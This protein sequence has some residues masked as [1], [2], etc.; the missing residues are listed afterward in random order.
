MQSIRT[1]ANTT[2][3]P[4]GNDG[5]ADYRHRGD[6]ETGLT[7]GAVSHAHLRRRPTGP[8]IRRGPRRALPDQHG[9][10]RSV[11]ANHAAAELASRGEEVRSEE[12]TSE[13]Q[14]RLHLVCRLLL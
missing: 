3:R 14:S 4:A 10:G 2:S 13:L 12:H 1:I 7:G 11:R 6:V 9:A 8:A 5:G